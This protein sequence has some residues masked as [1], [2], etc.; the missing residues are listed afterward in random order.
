MI[1]LGEPGPADLV[2]V[3]GHMRLTG[4]LPC[5]QWLPAELLVLL[6]LTAHHAK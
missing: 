6:G 5:P 4:L 3:E 2:V 1:V